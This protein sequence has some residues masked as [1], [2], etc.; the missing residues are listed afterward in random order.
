MPRLLV[1]KS[2]KRMAQPIG[3]CC[4][5]PVAAGRRFDTL[6]VTTR[7]SRRDLLIQGGLG[8][9]GL[10]AGGRILLPHVIP[11]QAAPALAG[12]HSVTITVL[13]HQKLRLKL[14][15][16]EIPRFE[17]AMAARGSSIKVHL[18]VGPPS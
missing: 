16:A 7:L 13:E 1:K 11:A 18:Q 8:G 2:Q 15:K 14:L 3:V 10:G 12:A 17:A 9:A 4:V 6:M 5:Q